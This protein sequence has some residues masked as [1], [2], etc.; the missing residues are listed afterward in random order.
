[1]QVF[2]GDGPN[3][4]S[5]NLYGYR[6][7]QECDGQNDPLVAPEPQKNALYTI[8]RTLL[9]F[10][11]LSNFQVGPRQGGESRFHRCPDG[12]NFRILHGNRILSGTYNVHD[13]RNRQNGQAV[14][15]VELTKY[16]PGE[17]REFDLF[18]SVRPSLPF[19]VKWKKDLQTPHA[20]VPGNEIFV[21]TPD[22]NCIP[23]LL[24]AILALGFPRTA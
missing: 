9:D 3:P 8:Q 11:S 24:P 2:G 14:H 18:E 21:L 16:I 10:H 5:L 13:T 19:S 15:R 20:Q 17:K 6:A 7:L 4:V 1:M 22:A 23:V 12:G